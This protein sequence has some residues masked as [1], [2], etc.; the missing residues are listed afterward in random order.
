MNIIEKF[1][2]MACSK[3]KAVTMTQRGVEHRKVKNGWVPITNMPTI[4]LI[5]TQTE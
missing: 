1:K 4:R 5:D 3:E 2:N